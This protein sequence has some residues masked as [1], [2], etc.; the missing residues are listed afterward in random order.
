MT[1]TRST[2]LRPLAIVSSRVRSNL[3]ALPLQLLRA[4]WDARSSADANDS[5]A[6][7]TMIGRKAFPPRVIRLMS[8]AK[9]GALLRSADI[10]G[11]CDAIDLPHSTEA[12]KRANDDFPVP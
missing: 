5:L 12:R 11:S 2:R 7:D 4:D 8:R 6:P 10:M 9:S 1:S 3:A